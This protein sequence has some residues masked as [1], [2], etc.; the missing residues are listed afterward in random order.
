LRAA[1]RDIHVLQRELAHLLGELH[2]E[3]HLQQQVAQLVTQLLRVV[4]VQGGEGLVRL[5]QQVGLER[6]VGLGAIPGATVGAPQAGD[7]LPQAVEGAQLSFGHV[8]RSSFPL[9]VRL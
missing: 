3:K 7:Y 5:L 6:R 9:D 8:H 4:L 2:M 1:Q